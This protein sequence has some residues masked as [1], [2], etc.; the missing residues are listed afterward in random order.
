MFLHQ[1]RDAKEGM[2]IPA[3]VGIQKFFSDSV[4]F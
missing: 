3:Q 1:V 2:V 4:I